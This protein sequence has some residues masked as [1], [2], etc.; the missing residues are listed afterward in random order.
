MATKTASKITGKQAIQF[1]QSR[2]GINSP[3]KYAVQVINTNPYKDRIIV[4]LKAQSPTGLEQAKEALRA[5]DY[6]KAGNTNMSTSVFA[7][8]SFIPAKGEY[9][10]VM[11]DY[12]EARDGS[13]VL[14]VTHISEMVAKTTKKISLGDEFANLLD[15]PVAA[16]TDEPVLD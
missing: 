7:D 2:L 9:V 6:D 11:V 12:V 5:K 4:G 10:N 3:G 14:G 13:Q 16:K 15:E 8:A 1:I